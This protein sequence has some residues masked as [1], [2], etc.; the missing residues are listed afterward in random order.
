MEY[1]QYLGLD[2]EE[3]A[4]LLRQLGGTAG[5]GVLCFEVLEDV[6]LVP[7][8]SLT[9]KDLEVELMRVAIARQAVMDV[10]ERVPGWSLLGLGAGVSTQLTQKK[11][12]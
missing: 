5:F 6:S 8:M 1:R 9:G 7:N 11:G 10:F 2:R 4:S 3:K 12:N